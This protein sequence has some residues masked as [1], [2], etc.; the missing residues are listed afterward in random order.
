MEGLGEVYQ[1]EVQTRV[2]E[3]R[4]ESGVRLYSTTVPTG[5]GIRHKKVTSL[6]RDK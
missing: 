4:E 1:P 3:C 2:R 6:K 5:R